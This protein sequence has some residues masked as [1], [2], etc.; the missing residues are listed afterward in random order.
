MAPT[1]PRQRVR[2]IC[3]CKCY[4]QPRIPLN[5]GLRTADAYQVLEGVTGIVCHM[6]SRVRTA[7]VAIVLGA[8]TAAF[9]LPAQAATCTY[10]AAT[11]TVTVAVGSGESATIA[12][13]VD[14]ITLDGVAC[15]AATVQTT[16][17]IVV[18]GTGGPTEVAIDLSGGPFEP[19]ATLET[20]GG[21]SEIEFTVDLSGGAPTL[22]IAGGPGADNIVLGTGGINLNAVEANGDV[23]VSI[24]GSPA[25]V[26]MG[27]GGDDILSVAGT[28]G[29]G[30]P[31][32]V[33]T[34]LGGDGTD[35]LLGALGGSTFDGGAGS[36]E[37]DFGASVRLLDADLAAGQVTHEGGAVDLLSGIEDL[38]GSPGDDRIVG[39]GANNVIDGGDG[40]DTIDFSAAS[41]MNVD[42][43]V[44][45]AVGDGVDALSSIENVIGSPFDDH[46]VGSGDAN[47]L[48][49]GPSDDKIDGGGGDDTLT[50][51]AGS[52]T[53]SFQSAT[54]GVTVSLTK[55]T[56]DGAGADTLA[57]FE[58]VVGTREADEIHGDGAR[59]RLDGRRGPDQVYGGAGGDNILGGDA[60]DLLFGQ[61][62]NDLLLGDS[63]KDRLDGG[64]DRDVCKG[65]SGPDSFV[66][67]ETVKAGPPPLI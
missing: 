9:P 34:L 7:V 50:G 54:A 66:F 39:N 21:A 40:D 31:A 53:V 3:R 1:S 47:L 43:R 63:A 41:A 59:N 61:S 60:N 46:I 49:G 25:I 48:D 45:R 19:G 51:G 35:R 23:D 22:R 55:G 33:A 4:L 17:T 30:P 20:D 18:N 14:L 65:G 16:D 58:N 38:T 57:G 42:L 32:P 26:I 13:S 27:G 37:V 15:G 12:R 64:K 52:D 8:A 56:A 2:I 44:G 28:A 36:D 29:T 6:R 24:S 67:C 11:L 62:G 10:D 5:P